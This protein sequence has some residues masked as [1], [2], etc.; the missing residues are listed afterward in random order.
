[1]FCLCSQP[2]STLACA[3]ARSRPVPSLRL[4]R[5]NIRAHL[6]GLGRERCGLMSMLRSIR[7]RG[8]LFSCFSFSSIRE[9]LCSSDDILEKFSTIGASPRRNST[10]HARARTRTAP[11]TRAHHL[12]V[13]T[14]SATGKHRRA[15]NRMY[16]IKGAMGGLFFLPATLI[17]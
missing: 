3:Q 7:L 4:T 5:T 16:H 10:P 9:S 12:A 17:N 8:S 15:L 11:L 6:L 13:K 2:V 1:M 14:G